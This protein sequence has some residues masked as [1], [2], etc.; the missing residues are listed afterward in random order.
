MAETLKK[1]V[2]DKAGPCGDAG[3]ASRRILLRA[4][5][6]QPARV[7]ARHFTDRR[8]GDG[9]QEFLSRGHAKGGFDG[10][11]RSDRRPRRSIWTDGQFNEL[12]IG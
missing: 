7:S 10:R 6:A 3:A 12:S 8:G 1:A 9:R 5:D 4:R 11:Y 2:M